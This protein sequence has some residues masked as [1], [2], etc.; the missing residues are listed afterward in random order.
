MN[1]LRLFLWVGILVVIVE[2]AYP[3]QVYLEIGN[4]TAY[5][6]D[7]V[8]NLGEDTL[9]T[10]YSKAYD[11]FIETGVRW[12]MY[13]NRLHM[14][15]GLSHNNYSI[16]TGFLAG[17]EEIPLH[18]D[19]SYGALKGGFIF[20]FINATKFKLQGHAHLSTDWLISG[21]SEYKNIVNNLRTDETF[22]RKL[23]RYHRGVSAAYHLSENMAFYL[24]YHVADSFKRLNNDSNLEETYSL[25]TNGFSLG[26]L[27]N[28]LKTKEDK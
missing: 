19:L 16:D 27:V 23:I 24:S 18:Y 5:F 3:Q 4:A 7:Y 8:N 6:K 21:T 9:N 17:N 2:T 25:H 14:N 12:N 20:S 13:K 1:T 22:A 11:N 28:F 26:V 15:I 10:G